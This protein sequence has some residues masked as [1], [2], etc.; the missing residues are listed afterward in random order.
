M[1]SEK[2]DVIVKEYNDGKRTVE[3]FQEDMLCATP[4]E[5]RLVYKQIAPERWTPH[6][7]EVCRRIMSSVNGMREGDFDELLDVPLIEQ[8][9]PLWIYM[10]EYQ[11]GYIYCIIPC[12]NR[13]FKNHTPAEVAIRDKIVDFIQSKLKYPLYDE[14]MFRHSP[15]AEFLNDAQ[16]AIEK[17]RKKSRKAAETRSRRQFDFQRVAARDK[18]RKASAAK[19]AAQR[20]FSFLNV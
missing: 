11:S 2:L 18:R 1:S 4:S 19:N 12:W 3:Q 20:A 10:V 6:V 14:D 13:F 17:R 9:L 8:T 7:L 16:L 15:N 5:R